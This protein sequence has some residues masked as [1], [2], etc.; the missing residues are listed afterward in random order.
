MKNLFVPLSES[1]LDFLDLFLFY[2][3]V[4]EEDFEDFGESFDV[5]IFDISSL[6]GFLATIVKWF[7]NH[8]VSSYHMRIPIN[9]NYLG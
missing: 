4:G 9:K 8:S 6:Y 5:G 3:R 2:K 7:I 1:G